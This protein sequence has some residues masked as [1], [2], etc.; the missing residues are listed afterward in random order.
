MATR[1]NISAAFKAKAALEA[2]AGEAMPAAAA[3]SARHQVH[4]NPIAK[5][6][7]RAAAEIEPRGPPFRFTHRVYHDRAAKSFQILILKSESV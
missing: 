4:P 1:R 7:R 6:K 2:L 5:W 3:L